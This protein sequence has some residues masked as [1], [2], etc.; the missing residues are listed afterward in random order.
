MEAKLKII[1][2]FHMIQI[3]SFCLLLKFIW[4]TQDIY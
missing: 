2:N 3:S 4:Y 1:L